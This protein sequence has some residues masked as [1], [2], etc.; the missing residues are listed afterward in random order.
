MTCLGWIELHCRMLG[1]QNDTRA[2]IM[3]HPAFKYFWVFFFWAGVVYQLY[4]SGSLMSFFLMKAELCAHQLNSNSNEFICKFSSST[5]I[6]V[7]KCNKWTIY[8]YIMKCRTK[9]TG[10]RLWSWLDFV[11]FASFAEYSKDKLIL[12]IVSFACRLWFMCD[13]Y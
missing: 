4:F 1:M 3:S 7:T 10:R 12:F 5:E 8:F 2:C 9:W 13:A 6:G 11:R